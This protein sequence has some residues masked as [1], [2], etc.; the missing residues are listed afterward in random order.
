MKSNFIVIFCFT[1][2][3][4]LG[5][6]YGEGLIEYLNEL[7]TYL[8]YALILQVGLNIG[9]NGAIGALLKNIKPTTLLLPISTVVGTL[10][11]AAVASF[12]INQW[13]MAECMAVGSGFGYY[14]L[15]SLLITQLKSATSGIE[16]ATQLGAVALL[17]NIFREIM[18][19]L[20]AP[21]FVRIFGRFAPIAAAGSTSMD[22]CL[23]IIS[24]YSGEK[25]IPMAIIHGMCIDMS[26]PFLVTFFCQ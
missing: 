20:G 10:L 26:V 14:S 15:S 5:M 3:I 25:M 19:L 8:L 24:R 7:P 11:F 16:V 18:A 17:A 22:V 4:M 1:M 13:T 9:A 12:A 2:G 21:L 6:S 23:P